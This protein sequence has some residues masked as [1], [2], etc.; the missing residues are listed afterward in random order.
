MPDSKGSPPPRA[1]IK[2]I[3]GMFCSGCSSLL[4]ERRAHE[5]KDYPYCP[6]CDQLYVVKGE[7]QI[8]YEAGEHGGTDVKRRVR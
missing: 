8:T 4:R 7:Q 1:T 3:G 2:E 5:G 6:K